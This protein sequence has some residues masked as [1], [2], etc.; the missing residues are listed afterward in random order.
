MSDQTAYR[1]MQVAEAYGSKLTTV[2]NLDPTALYALAAP[3]TPIEV[4]EEIEKMIEAGVVHC[5]SAMEAA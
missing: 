1:F 5:L 3:E 4:R 2:I